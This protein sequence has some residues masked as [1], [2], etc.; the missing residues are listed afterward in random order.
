MPGKDKCWYFLT[1]ALDV[2]VK[3]LNEWWDSGYWGDVT[4]PDPPQ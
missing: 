1:K 2:T 4:N 3:N